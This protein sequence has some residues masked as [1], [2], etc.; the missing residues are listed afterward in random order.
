M[1][2]N[3]KCVL[4]ITE[5]GDCPSFSNSDLFDLFLDDLGGVDMTVVA[6]ESDI[7]NF[8]IPMSILVYTNI[9]N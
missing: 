9:S 5:A 2:I 8:D 7:A 4:K 1:L 6:T 3:K